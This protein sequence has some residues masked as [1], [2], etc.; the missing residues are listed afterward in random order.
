MKKQYTRKQ[1][2]EALAYWEK[3]LRIGNYRKLN[4]SKEDYEAKIREA[5]AYAKRKNLA[6]T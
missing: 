4:E 5:Y 2:T 1:I 6:T 3:Q